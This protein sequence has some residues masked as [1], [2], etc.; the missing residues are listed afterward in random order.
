MLPVCATPASGPEPEARCSEPRQ[1]GMT[2]TNDS[3]RA[4]LVAST[5]NP[6]DHLKSAMIKHRLAFALLASL[7]AA[8]GCGSADPEA[9]FQGRAGSSGDA[10][11]GQG[12][13]HQG[14]SAGSH[15]GG[16]D[17]GGTTNGG[18]AGTELA[19]TPCTSPADCTALELV[20]D[21][22]TSLCAEC[23]TDAECD[24]NAS[25]DDHTCVPHRDC[26]NSLG[27]GAGEVCDPV[28]SRCVTCTAV[29]DCPD[30]QTCVAHECTPI[31]DSD[32]DCV[33]Q[34]TL[35]DRAAGH[36]VECLRDGDCH[37]AMFC[38]AGECALDLCT[39]DE[40]RCTGANIEQCNAA[41]S[42]FEGVSTCA[43]RQTCVDSAEPARCDD[44]I[45]ELGTTA[46]V[47]DTLVTCSMDGLA[48]IN[49]TDC[50]A[51]G[52]V[53]D[54][55]ACHSPICAAATDFCES[56]DVYECSQNGLDKWLSW[57]C[58]PTQY[59]DGATA[60]CRARICVPTQPACDANVATTCNADGSGY[61]AAR[62]DC[63]GDGRVCVNGVC[64]SRICVPSQVFCENEDVYQCSTN[65]VSKSIYRNCTSTQYCDPQSL[66]C[67]T[68]NC[69]P[70]QATCDGNVKTTCNANGSGYA[71]SRQDCGSDVCLGGACQTA[72]CV[73]NQ[74][75]C[76]GGNV[77]LCSANGLQQSLYSACTATEFCNEA[78]ALCTTQICAPNQPTCDGNAR[79]TCNAQGSGYTGTPTDCGDLSCFGGECRSSLFVEDF[80]DG[81]IDGWTKV[82]SCVNATVTPSAA[83]AGTTRGLSLKNTGCSAN[84]Y[85]GIYHTLPDLSPTSISWWARS[86]GSQYDAHF[87]LRDANTT[88]SAYLIYVWF[89]V[90]D[91]HIA[92]SGGSNST[93]SE[94]SANVWY[95]LEMRDIDWRAGTFDFYVNG[96]FKATKAF[97]APNGFG[98]LDLFN[99]PSNA[100]GEFDEIVFAP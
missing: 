67:E 46:C 78:T 40:T 95:Q 80:E 21:P 49:S 68:Q 54:A 43:E 55:G 4:T 18:T 14:G 22:V 73:P 48:I 24:G 99:F 29:A 16:T 72:I 83:A 74:R 2:G 93:F 30:E 79:T 98:R 12:G 8:I 65:G 33:G 71:G 94:T 5:P 81:D 87:V 28:E 25:C 52:A 26:T 38:S 66:S 41:G 59:C 31:C 76:D 3:G 10:G 6:L 69:V 19:P 88:S 34:D 51:D 13:I 56:G 37:D 9:L 75:F 35:C 85:A 7:G 44:W 60:T 91:L 64:N 84:N 86:S 89:A 15:V 92:V 32:P 45:C 27:C 96:V 82:E 42:A 61:A 1:D 77:Y 58:T 11:A 53:C 63:S 23:V 20:C 100:F 50:S 17:A 36:C 70:N 57:D 90:G 47:G 62:T 39:P 97:S